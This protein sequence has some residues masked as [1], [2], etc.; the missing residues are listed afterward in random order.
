MAADA[1]I[2]DAALGRLVTAFYARVREDA[3]LGPIFN[4]A[5]HDWSAHLTTLIAF[6]LSVMPTSG[7]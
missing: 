7:R 2:D 3:E 4:D 6:W 1:R 5:V